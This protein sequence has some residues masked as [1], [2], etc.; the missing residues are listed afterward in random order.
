MIWHIYLKEMIDALRDRKTIL[1][2][3][4]FPVLF[5]I[6]LVMFMDQ[7]FLAEKKETI[8]VAV[9][10]GA[11]AQVGEWLKEID[12][13]QVSYV[14]DPISTVKDGKAIV[15][16]EANEE[17]YAK[18]VSNEPSI[19]LHA[20]EA[21]M[22]GSATIDM[23]L[24]LFEG[25]KQAVA[26]QALTEKGLDLSILNPFTVAF[27][28]ISGNDDGS[29]YMISIFSQMIIIFAVLFGQLSVA[30]DLFAGEKER[31]TMEALIMTPVNRLHLIVGKW[32]TISSLGIMSGLFSVITF[33]TA[34]TFFTDK[35][36]KALNIS[37]NALFFITSLGVGLIFFSLLI[38]SIQMIFSLL[39]NTMKEAQNYVSPIMLLMMIPYFLLIGVSVN[40]LQTKHF[41]I[42]V[43][44]IYALI[45]QLIYGIYEP[46]SAIYVVASSSVFIV[47]CF[48]IAFTMFKKSKWVLGKS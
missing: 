13:L 36:A 12:H 6:G 16:I 5:N 42:P 23:L 2:S 43:M 11:D 31:K 25:K 32:L 28:S 9:N 24:N 40:E 38:A 18:A 4:L 10:E 27:Q 1:L 41:L 15:A 29:I 20:D 19:I 48:T 3:V 30:N 17:L 46:T 34:V 45:K 39:A 33:V 8:K 22:K 44:N 21:S 47:I 37:D 14:K 7:V 35:M 26:A